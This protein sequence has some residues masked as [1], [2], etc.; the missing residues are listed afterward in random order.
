MRGKLYKRSQTKPGRVKSLCR[1]RSGV[2]SVSC[3]L[4]VTLVV[5]G[6]ARKAIYLQM[7]LARA[8]ACPNSIAR[9]LGVLV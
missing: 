1:L 3:P 4:I 8:I 2:Y 6:A 5:N 9:V 7:A